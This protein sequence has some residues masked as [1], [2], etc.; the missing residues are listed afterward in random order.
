MNIRID[1]ASKVPVY[2]QI[3]D[4]IKS[5][6]IS[7]AL[8][9]ASALPS[10]RALAQ[11]LD[12]HRNTVVK[13]Y[14]ELKSDAWIESRQGVGYVVAASTAEREPD[15]ET[16]GDGAP[17]L[18][19]VNWVGEVADK[20]LDMEKTFDDL[21]QRFTDESRYSL[22]SGIAARDVFS[23]ERVARDIASLVT[24][25]GPCQYCFSPYKGDRALRQKLVSFLGTKGIR[26]SSGE[27]QILSETNQALD[28]IVTLLVKPG[29]SVVMEEP[30]HPDMSR[31]MELAGAKILTVPVD[32]DGM[33]CEVLENLLNNTRPRLIFVNS[34]FHDPTG[35]ILSLE[36][37][38]RLVELSNIYRVPIIEE[39]AASELSYEGERLPPIKAFDTMGNVI[40]IYSFSL[41]FVPGLSLAFVVGNRDFIRAM[42]YLVSVRLMAS[43][44]LTQK[45][46]GMYLDDG[47]YY[48]ALGAF[49]AAYH[50]KRDLVCRRLDEMAPLGVRYQRPK[51][52][53]YVWCQLPDGVDSKSFISRAYNMGVTLIPGHVFYPFKNGGRDHIRINYSYESEERLAR[54]MDVLRKALEEELEE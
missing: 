6:I 8:P 14:S 3:A 26:A 46:L 50:R 53:I 12:V 40:Y 24:G 43:D 49:R 27:I 23:P 30:V 17:V 45:L 31:A 39:D 7:G 5:Q 48:T 54:G 42:S 38:K 29:D 36:R 4:Q 13:A 33:N 37:R 35:S 28:F 32:E 16:G 41:T 1:K 52:G 47:S 10:E 20:Y 11:L 18:G 21:F 25:S 34:S 9:R 15:A 51:G 44:W 2:L 19:R 22:G